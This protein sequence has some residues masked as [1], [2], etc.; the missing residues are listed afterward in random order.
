[1]NFLLILSYLVSIK[2]IILYNKGSVLVQLQN[3]EKASQQCWKSFKERREPREVFANVEDKRSEIGEVPQGNC[4]EATFCALAQEIQ[5]AT[6][7]KNCLSCSN[8]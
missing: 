4:P 3:E 8:S 1:M 2:F 5:R 7:Q 6:V